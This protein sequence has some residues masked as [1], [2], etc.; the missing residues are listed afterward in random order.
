MFSVYFI[1]IRATDLETIEFTNRAVDVLINAAD[2]GRQCKEEVDWLL[3]TIAKST[4]ANTIHDKL[5]ELSN[6]QTRVCLLLL[7]YHF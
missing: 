7:A 5:I 6:K 2:D 4:G 3:S 1:N